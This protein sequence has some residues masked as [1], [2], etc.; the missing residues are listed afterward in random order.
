[1]SPLRIAAMT[2]GASSSSGCSRGWVTGVHGLSRRSAW[3]DTRDDVPQVLEVEQPG[4]LEDVL[5]LGG[6][7][8]GDLLAH[9]RA[10]RPAPTSTRTTSPKRRR[11][12][13]SST[14]RTRSSASSETVKSASRVT[15][16]TRVVDDLHARE[17]RRR[18][19]WRSGP[20]AGRTCAR[21]RP[22][23]SAAAS[24]SAPSRARR[25]P[26]RRPGRGRPRRAT[27]RGWRCRG[28]AAR[29]RPP[30]ASAPGRSGAG[31]ARRA[32][33]APPR[34]SR[35]RR[36]S[37]CRARPAPGAARGPA[38]PPGGRGARA[39]STRITVDRLARRAPVLQRRLDPR[40][41]LVVQPGDADHEE[42]VEVRG[43]DR[44]EL[45]ALEQ[46]RRPGPRP[47]RARAS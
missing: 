21:R 8:G 32:P 13:S 12:S 6:Q 22:A 36:R 30:A 20:R 15:R 33:R 41:D 34:R 44:A 16:K 19:S 28:T 5:L 18:G 24:P 29:A 43:R 26:P 14:A 47:A 23:R 45:H 3:P 1:M 11:R 46:R 40:V 27:A 9:G 4:D 39:P 38:A 37:G 17:Q 10:H 42:L 25:P 7:R 2:S 31:S 35:R